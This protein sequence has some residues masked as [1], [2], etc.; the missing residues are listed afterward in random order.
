MRFKQHHFSLG[1]SSFVHVY[2]PRDE[3]GTELDRDRFG[4]D[5]FETMVATHKP[6]VMRVKTGPEADPEAKGFLLEYE[7]LRC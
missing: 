6:L 5:S 3:E 2:D 7:Y 1:D 4:G